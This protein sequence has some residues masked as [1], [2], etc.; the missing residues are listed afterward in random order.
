MTLRSRLIVQLE[1][2]KKKKHLGELAVNLAANRGLVEWKERERKRIRISYDLKIKLIER[3]GSN[4]T[5]WSDSSSAETE[6]GGV[7][8]ATWQLVERKQ[9]EK[10]RDG[11]PFIVFL[12]C[13]CV[14]VTLH[15]DNTLQWGAQG[16]R[17]QP[18][19]RARAR[20]PA[21]WTVPVWRAGRT[22]LSRFSV[23]F[24]CCIPRSF[25]TKRSFN[26]TSDCIY[27][28]LLKQNKP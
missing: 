19:A 17:N 7:E 3:C 24:L 22:S 18:R 28:F 13:C 5:I 8:R 12:G 10:K 4:F 6:L 26:V 14:C 15:T 1:R 20:Q 27:T 11:V 2:E 21:Q 16:F 23:W 9:E 25:V